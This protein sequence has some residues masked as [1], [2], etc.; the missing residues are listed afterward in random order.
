MLTQSLKEMNAA[1]AGGVQGHVAPQEE[2]KEDDTDTDTDTD[3][4]DKVDKKLDITMAAPI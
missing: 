2:I 1:S 4:S 3:T